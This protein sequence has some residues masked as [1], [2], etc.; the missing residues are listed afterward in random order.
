LAGQIYPVPVL[1]LIMSGA[2]TF[3]RRLFGHWS[4]MPLIGFPLLY[5]NVFLVGTMNYIFGMGLALWALVAWMWLRERNVL[6]RLVV[7]TAFVLALFFCHMF[8]VGLYD[9]GLFDFEI[10]LL[11]LI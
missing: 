10:T 5:N 11:L 4:I 1:V 6:L 3:N 7:S 8:A 9:L 2:L